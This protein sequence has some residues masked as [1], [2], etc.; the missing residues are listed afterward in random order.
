MVPRKANTGV[1]STTPPNS[2][3][4]IDRGR[5]CVLFN[6]QLSASPRADKAVTT[7][8]QPGP[9]RMACGTANIWLGRIWGHMHYNIQ[10]MWYHSGT[11]IVAYRMT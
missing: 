1:G 2:Y 10:R 7:A 4:C 5:Q 6:I 9:P 8:S 3:H 11:G